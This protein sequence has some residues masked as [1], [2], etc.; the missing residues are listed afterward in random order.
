MQLFGKLSTNGRLSRPHWPHQKYI[1]WNHVANDST[2][3]REKKT[4]S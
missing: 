3:Y 1:T 4:G 2:V